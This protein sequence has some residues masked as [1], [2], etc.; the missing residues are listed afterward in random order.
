MSKCGPAC[1]STRAVHLG[2]T[3]SLKFPAFLRAFRKY[4]KE[5]YPPFSCQIMRKHS[6]HRV[7]KL[8]NHAMPMKCCGFLRTIK[9]C[10]SLEWRSPLGGA[11]FGNL[12]IQSVKRPM[13]KVVGRTNLTYDELQT[14]VVGIESIVN[15]RLV[16]YLYDDAESISFSLTPSHSVYG[17]RF[18]TM[19][20]SQHYEIVSTYHSLTRKA[21]HH[22]CARAIYKAVEERVFFGFT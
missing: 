22:K 8:V 10:G 9:L 13:R 11:A 6:V 3:L 14:L 17:R 20:N 1:A 19:P 7:P 15:A 21:K 18:T 5:V 4:V 16:T 2:L 12:L